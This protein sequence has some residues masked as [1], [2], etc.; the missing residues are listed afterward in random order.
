MKQQH[1]DDVEVQIAGCD[2]ITSCCL[3]PDAKR[4]MI[5]SD[6]A[7]RVRQALAV[8][9]SDKD[10]EDAANRASALLAGDSFMAAAAFSRDRHRKLY[11][12]P[13]VR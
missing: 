2:H 12:G 6:A 10:L 13:L 8:H 5:D 3:V 4:A 9:P 7:D 1:L 11:D